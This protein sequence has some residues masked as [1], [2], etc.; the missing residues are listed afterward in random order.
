[1]AVVSTQIECELKQGYCGVCHCLFHFRCYKNIDSYS[2]TF[3]AQHHGDSQVKYVDGSALILLASPMERLEVV[4]FFLPV[5]DSAK[6]PTDS[7]PVA[8]KRRIILE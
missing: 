6:V 2:Y 1:M 3:V 5:V 4:T 7:T 8:P